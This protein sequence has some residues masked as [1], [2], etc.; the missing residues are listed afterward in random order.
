[1]QVQLNNTSERRWGFVRLTLGVLQ[2]FGAAR[3]HRF[4]T[5]SMA[6]GEFRFAVIREWLRSLIRSLPE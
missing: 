5:E 1:M 4:I 2:V 3:A 6:Q